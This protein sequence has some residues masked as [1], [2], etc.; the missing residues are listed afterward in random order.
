MMNEINY[1]QGWN[2]GKDVYKA[3]SRLK[4]YKRGNGRR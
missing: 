2:W 3:K 1:S 4:P